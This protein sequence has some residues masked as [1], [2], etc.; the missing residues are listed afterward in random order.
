VIDGLVI[1][2]ASF[3]KA[4]PFQT[5][6]DQVLEFLTRNRGKAYNDGELKREMLQV[7]GGGEILK[8][9]TVVGQ[10]TYLIATLDNLIADGKVV[11]RRPGIYVYYMAAPEPEPPSAEEHEEEHEDEPD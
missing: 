7:E 4:K 11:A 6:Y 3:E 2:N 9:F 1:D 8:S 5:L 10:T